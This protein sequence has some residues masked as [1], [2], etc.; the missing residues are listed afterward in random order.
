MM[1][2]RSPGTS[3]ISVTGRENSRIIV[4]ASS[5]AGG[6]VKTAGMDDIISVIPAAGS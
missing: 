6:P 4:S 2:S 1:A 5:V 3:V